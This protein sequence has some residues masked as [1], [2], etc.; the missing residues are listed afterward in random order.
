M[1]H[2]FI[3]NGIKNLISIKRILVG[4]I[5]KKYNTAGE[6]IEEVT[7]ENKEEMK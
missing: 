4:Y 7:K 2:I 1:D 5:K 3:I 6:L